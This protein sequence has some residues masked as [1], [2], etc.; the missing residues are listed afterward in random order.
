MSRFV[1]PNSA[2]IHTARHFLN[3]NRPFEDPTGKA[4]LEFHPKWAHLEPVA[5]VMVAAWG[6]WCKRNG[7]PVEA[8]NVG[9]HAN[10]A[11]RMRLFQHLGIEFDPGITEHEI[12]R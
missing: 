12:G 4:I 10:Y 3:L 5:L 9:R 2:T 6:A 7:V 11:A 8:L 1:L